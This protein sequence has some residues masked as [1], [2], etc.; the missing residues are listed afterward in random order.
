MAWTAG[1]IF[2]SLHSGRGSGGGGEKTVGSRVKAGAAPRGPRVSN[3]RV[4]LW[5]HVDRWIVPDPTVVMR[6]LRMIR[7]RDGRVLLAYNTIS[8]GVLK[9]AVSTDDGGSWDEVLAL[10]ENPGMEF[11]Y[12]AV[13][14]DSEGLLHITYTYDRIQIKVT[15]S[16]LVVEPRDH[17]DPV[18]IE[19]IRGSRFKLLQHIILQLN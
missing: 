4:S 18:N 9:V 10:E 5:N 11:S 6:R 1:M 7:L 13:I 19:C 16:F 17:L 15:T 2:W 8:R 3:P 12:P 14:E